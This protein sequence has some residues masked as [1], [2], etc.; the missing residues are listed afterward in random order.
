MSRR[1]ITKLLTQAEEEAKRLK[2]EFTSVEHVLLAA[3]DDSGPAGKILR[4]FGVTR[5]RLMRAL[6]EVRGSQRVTSQNPEGDV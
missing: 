1:G 3:T 6:Q 4:E 5:E 2:D